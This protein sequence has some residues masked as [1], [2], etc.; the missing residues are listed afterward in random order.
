MAKF[1][2]GDKVVRNANNP[3]I[4]YDFVGSVGIIRRGDKVII[5]AVDK[6]RRLYSVEGSYIKKPNWSS[7]E[8]NFDLVP[9][10]PNWRQVLTNGKQ[11]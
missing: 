8:D 3:Y 10:N 6:N 1:K 11:T 4:C 2:V 7:M 9:N 5:S